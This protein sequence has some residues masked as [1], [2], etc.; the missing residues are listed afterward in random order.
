MK[1]LLAVALAAMVARYLK[2]RYRE[3]QLDRTNPIG[4]GTGETGSAFGH[5]FASA[6]GGRRYT[7]GP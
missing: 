1:K 2:R 5:G 4:V 3:H 7:G 6:V